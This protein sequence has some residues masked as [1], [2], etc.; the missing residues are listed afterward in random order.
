MVGCIWAFHQ[1]RWL[2]GDHGVLPAWSSL[3]TSWTRWLGVS[4]SDRLLLL[5]L[6]TPLADCSRGLHY[7]SSDEWSTWMA[8]SSPCFWGLAK[9]LHAILCQMPSQSL[10]SC[11]TYCAGFVDTSLWWFSSA[12]LL[13]LPNISACTKTV[14]TLCGDT[15]YWNLHVIIIC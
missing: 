4:I 13:I 7:W 15:L 11:G 8:L 2:C 9:G 12:F 10:W 5:S 3:G 14:H 1:W 6:R